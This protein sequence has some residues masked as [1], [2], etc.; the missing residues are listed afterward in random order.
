MILT[1]VRPR[2][3]SGLA[4]KLGFGRAEIALWSLRYDHFS[5][6]EPL[7]LL[8]SLDGLVGIA[9]SICDLMVGTEP[10]LPFFY[11]L[12]S[13]WRDRENLSKRLNQCWMT[14]EPAEQATFAISDFAITISED[15]Q[16]W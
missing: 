6:Q 3:I 8:V 11:L 4:I 2:T 10:N 13:K 14:A 12:K 15:G 1:H 5:D 9:E 7:P 16:S